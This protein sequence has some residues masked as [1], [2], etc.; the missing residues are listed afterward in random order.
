MFLTIG[1]N[2]HI[3]AQSRS[4]INFN[5]GWKFLLGDEPAAKNNDFND[6]KWRTLDLPHDWSFEGSFSEQNPTTFNEGALPGGIGWY[7]KTFSV[8][9][10]SIN[11]LIY[12]NFD[13]VYKNSE[14]WIN[15]FYLGKRP[16]G[17]ISFR[18]ELT[19]HL[20]FGSEKNVIVVN[21]SG[22]NLCV[23]KTNADGSLQPVVQN[24]AHEGYGVNVERV[25]TLSVMGKKKVRFTKAGTLA[26][27][28]PNYKKAIV[29]L[30]EGEVIDFY[31]NV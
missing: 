30:A 13:G 8:P 18:Y 27:R 2:P 4:I 14:V 3:Y 7:R 29:T 9:A 10:S 22:G 19:S 26:G 5:T 28:K 16:N 17:Y 1:I 31:S 20:K 11:K 21:Y 6:S 12:I 24:I 25:N 23:L 15:G